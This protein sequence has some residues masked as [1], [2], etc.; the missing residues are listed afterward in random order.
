MVNTNLNLANEA[1]N[2]GVSSFP[3]CIFLLMDCIYFSVYERKELG[4]GVDHFEAKV[5]ILLVSEKTVG[6]IDFTVI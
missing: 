5:G 6:R 3:A 1:Y 2:S 4:C